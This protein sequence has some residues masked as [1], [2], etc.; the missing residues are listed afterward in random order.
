MT[1]G[2]R[3]R[4]GVATALSL[5][6][7]P[8]CTSSGGEEDCG[9]D[10]GCVPSFV[11]EGVVY[12]IGCLG[13]APDKVGPELPAVRVSTTGKVTPL[14]SLTG[15]TAGQALAVHVPTNGCG[16]P[17]DGAADWSLSFP[18]RGPDGWLEQERVTCDVARAGPSVRQASRCDQRG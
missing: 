9:P 17:G 5:L 2:G 12:G 8:A 18:L 4:V 7:L 11:H 14:R 6:L 16:N 3:L 15:W 10:A 13:V 1:V